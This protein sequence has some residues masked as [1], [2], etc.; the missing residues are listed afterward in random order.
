[1]SGL[2]S[3]SLHAMP[4]L[5][6]NMGGEMV[7][8]LHQ[9]L[10]AQSVNIDK[11][12]KVLKD[13]MMSMFS[14][15]FID[16]LFKP[17]CMYSLQSTKQI[18]EKLAHSS[19][20]RLNTSS[21]EKLF[22]LMSMGVK[23]QLLCC[24][25]PRQYMHVTMNHLQTMRN[26]IGLDCE[27]IQNYLQ[28]TEDHLARVYSSSSFTSGNWSL[29]K[30]SI[31]SFFQGKRVKVSLFLQKKVQ[32]AQDGK[33]FISSHGL[34]PYGSEPIGTTRIYENNYLV[35]QYVQ[36]IVMSMGN[37]CTLAT[38]LWDEK[39]IVGHNMYST[40]SSIFGAENAADDTHTKDI[41]LRKLCSLFSGHAPTIE[42]HS[43]SFDSGTRAFASK[44]AADSSALSS[45][46]ARAQSKMNAA[47]F[48][49]AD[50]SSSS[51]K[52]SSL[53]G[54]LG[55]GSLGGFEGKASRAEADMDMGGLINIFFEEIDGTA[56]CKTMDDMM[57]QLDLKDKPKMQRKSSSS[58][59]GAKAYAKADDDDD[60]DD[61]L[62]LMDSV[63]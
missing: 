8:I 63:K 28:R 15:I 22:D 17:Q 20:M 38:E 31:L 57:E 44:Y 43:S 58:E 45:D 41:I 7:Y 62:A 52:I 10:R 47:F 55:S 23:Y 14:P 42:H 60:D 3:H 39:F 37:T 19:I 34:L 18:F 56:D 33:L 16:E 27:P 25:S 6:I 24:T 53:A 54:L 35:K 46:A 21:M 2:G 51:A 11:E 26:I 29:L 9:R 49:T 40:T 5:I 1:M 50:S 30:T 13:V 48:R 32:S 36:N 12:R 61:L 59:S 4:I